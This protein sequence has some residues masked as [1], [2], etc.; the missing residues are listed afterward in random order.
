[1]G[2]DK[3][4]TGEDVTTVQREAMAYSAWATNSDLTMPSSQPDAL[5]QEGPVAGG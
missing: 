3:K 5:P 2:G 4:L 1:M